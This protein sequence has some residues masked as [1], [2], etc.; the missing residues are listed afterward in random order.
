MKFKILL[1][2]AFFSGL[3][4]FSQEKKSQDKEIEKIKQV[5]QSAYVE[6]LQNEG[7]TV[8]INAGFHPD[9]AMLMPSKDGTLMRYSLYDWKKR[10][11]AD[12][13]D[14]KLPRKADR[15]VSVKFLFVDVTGSAAVAKFEFYVGKQLTYIDY[16]SLYKFGE[17]WKIV[18]KIYSAP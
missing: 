5:I 7:D 18:S 13:A 11:K 17:N 15:R 14:K 4:A 9:F 16:Q 3:T 6:G 12:L 1:I 2:I 8:K 10:I